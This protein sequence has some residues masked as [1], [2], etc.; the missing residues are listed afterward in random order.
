MVDIAAIF[1]R[2][3]FSYLFYLQVIFLPCFE[4]DGLSVQEKKQK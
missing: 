1:D 4:S 2:N 3:N